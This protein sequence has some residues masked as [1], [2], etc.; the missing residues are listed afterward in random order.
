MQAGRKCVFGI[1]L[2]VGNV[3][4]PTVYQRPPSNRTPIHLYRR[5]AHVIGILRRI[6]V[7]CGPKE[8]LA[9]LASNGSLVG[10]AL[11]RRCFNQG[12]KN[13]LEVKGRA[14][15]DLEDVSCSGLLGECFPGL[16]KQAPAS[17][18]PSV[19]VQAGLTLRYLPS[20]SATTSKSCE[21]FQI[22]RRSRVS[23]STR[24]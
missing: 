19:T 3:N 13:C 21:T 23:S 1:G 15:D 4:D 16:I 9:D 10:I 18:Q 6:A 2:D 5:F 24:C 22:W 8:C 12:I 17:D 11:A 20:K 7:G 14:A